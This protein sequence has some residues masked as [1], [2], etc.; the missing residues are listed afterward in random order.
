MDRRRMCPIPAGFRFGKRVTLEIATSSR[1]KVMC[2]CDCGFESKVE[3]RGLRLM[4]HP[5]CR[6]CATLESAVKHGDSQ[7]GKSPFYRL[8]YIYASILRRCKVKDGIKVFPG[9]GGRGIK[10]CDEW[11][12]DYLTF[13]KWAIANGYS[14]EL[15]IDRIDNNG[16]YEPSNC[17]W[18]TVKEQS[19]NRRSNRFVTAFGESKTITEWSEDERCVV[20]RTAIHDRIARGIDPEVAMASPNYT[21]NRKRGPRVAKPKEGLPGS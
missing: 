3:A 4:R 16:N 13:K 21:L 5:K 20:G 1:Q 9:Y 14:D 8:Y 15:T 18:V 6:Y 7:V 17:R 10:V 2:R 12:S 19:N 11:K